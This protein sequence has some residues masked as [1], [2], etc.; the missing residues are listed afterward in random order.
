MVVRVAIG[1]QHGFLQ[2]CVWFAIRRR[3]RFFELVER[4][5]PAPLVAVAGRLVEELLVDQ[6]QQRAV[7]VR[8][9]ENGDQRLAFRHGPPRPGELQLLVRDD[10]L[11]DAA[12]V[13]LLAVFGV[14]HDMEAAADAHVGLR[15][16]H[17]TLIGSEPVH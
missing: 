11:I 13:V 17:R 2:F 12:D 7:A 9:D 16:G 10:L 14:E 4:A 15:L 5:V 1:T 3:E 6:G 8:L